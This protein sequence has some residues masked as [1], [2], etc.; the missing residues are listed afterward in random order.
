MQR[1][2]PR[3]ESQF[4]LQH[5]RIIIHNSHYGECIT[6][7]LILGDPKTLLDDFFDTV[8]GKTVV[9]KRSTVHDFMTASF[10]LHGGAGLGTPL[11]GEEVGY[12]FGVV[13]DN[14]GPDDILFWEHE[15]GDVFLRKFV[16]HLV[17]LHL[18]FVELKHCRNVFLLHFTN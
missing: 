15:V 11:H 18:C 14:V 9:E 16:V 17:L 2:I 10:C 6:L 3:Q 7:K 12:L 4:I 1:S 13:F 5:N 8:F